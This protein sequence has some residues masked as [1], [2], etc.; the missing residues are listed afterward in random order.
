MG[1]ANGII[2]IAEELGKG[3][4]FLDPALILNGFVESSGSNSI[5]GLKRLRPVEINDA[6]KASTPFIRHC[7]SFWMI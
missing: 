7:V 6:E 3:S 1:S 4:Y 2:L 5:L